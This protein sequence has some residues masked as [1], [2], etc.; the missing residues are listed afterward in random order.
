MMENETWLDAKEALRLGFCDE[1]LY[2]DEQ[3]PEEE[4]EDTHDTERITAQLF[5]TR[6]MNA[7]IMNKLGIEDVKEPEKP[8][9]GFDGKTK[10][11]AMPYDILVQQ[12]ELLR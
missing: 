7:A 4:A 10:D 2:T 8:E 5:S 3:D 11:G 6:L 12:L 9:I 1:I